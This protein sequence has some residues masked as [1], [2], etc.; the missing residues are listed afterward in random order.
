MDRNQLLNL[1]RECCPALGWDDKY[2]DL[3]G[4]YGTTLSGLCTGWKWFEEDNITDYAKAN[5]YYPIT[6]ATKEE[7]LE[8]L[9]MADHYRLN[10]YKEWYK[11][12]KEKLSEKSSELDE[13]IGKTLFWL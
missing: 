9:A 4:K 1:V 12:S 3:F 13:F 5:G 11:K 2:P 6:S 10:Q 7:L 8:M